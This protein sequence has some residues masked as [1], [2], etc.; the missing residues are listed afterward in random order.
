MSPKRSKDNTEHHLKIVPKHLQNLQKLHITRIGRCVSGDYFFRF[1]HRIFGVQPNEEAHWQKWFCFSVLRTARR[2]RSSFTANASPPHAKLPW[3]WCDPWCDLHRIQ[4]HRQRWI[5][6]R[7]LGLPNSAWKCGFQGRLV[8]SSCPCLWTEWRILCPRS[9]FQPES[10]RIICDL[11]EMQP[12]C[13][14]IRPVTTTSAVVGGRILLVFRNFMRPSRIS[15]GAC[16]WRLRAS[17]P[18]A[19][20]SYLLWDSIYSVIRVTFISSLSRT[21]FFFTSHD[22]KRLLIS[23]SSSVGPIVSRNLKWSTSPP[24]NDLRVAWLSWI[25]WSK[26]CERV[27]CKKWFFLQRFPAHT[28]V[29]VT[30]LRA[31]VEPSH[32]RN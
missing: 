19:A 23:L 10:L 27:A 32:M 28:Q 5:E 8:D 12:D 31:A 13:F 3:M 16:L 4:T 15:Q 18:L 2:A 9:D 20:R 6:S 21:L 7:S 26:V 14:V 24:P 29:L 1:C 22:W 30:C 17:K 11:A 25:T